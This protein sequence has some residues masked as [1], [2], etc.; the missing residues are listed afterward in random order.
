MNFQAQ[1]NAVIVQFVIGSSFFRHKSSN[2]GIDQGSFILYFWNSF[3]HELSLAVL[4]N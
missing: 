3:E 4:K 2:L 1:L